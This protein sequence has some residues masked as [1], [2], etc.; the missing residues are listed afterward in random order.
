MP[1]SI[2]VT[3][4]NEKTGLVS[5]IPTDYLSIFPDYRE[6]SDDE[7]TK[8]R[9]KQEKELFGEYRTPA[10]KAK[11]ADKPAEAPVKEGN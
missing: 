11:A 8:L 4:V 6:L 7:I 9:R 3:A 1:E 10:P 2:L 5:E